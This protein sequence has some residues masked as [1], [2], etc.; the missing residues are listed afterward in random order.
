MIV[1]LLA[2]ALLLVA[3]TAASA[4]GEGPIV[5]RV[6]FEGNSKVKSEQLAPEMR[7]RAHAP[8]DARTAES[9]VARL[10]EIYRRS[11]RAA[12]QISYRTV[13]LENGRVDVVYTIA[14]GD[15]TGVKEI[16][17]IG[18]NVYS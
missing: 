16:R 14:E 12:A 5:N 6:A 18:N 13:P 3:P 1:A 17:F 4:K 15:K 9:D 7:T 10:K 11:G 2:A 8:F